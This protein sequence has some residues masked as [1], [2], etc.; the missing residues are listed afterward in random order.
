[1]HKHIIE[2][3]KKLICLFAVSFGVVAGMNAQKNTVLLY[4]DAGFNTTKASNDDLNKGFNMNLGVG[5]QFDHNWT[6]GLTGGYSTLRERP[7]GQ[8][9]WDLYD[10]YSFAPFIRYSRPMG[11]LFTFF[12]QGEFGYIGSSMGQTNLNTRSNYNGTY[13]SVFPAIGLNLG[14]GWALNFNVGGLGYSSIKHENSNS[15]SR[16]FSLTFGQ[17]YN[18]G[19]SWN[20]LCKTNKNFKKHNNREKDSDD[21]GYDNWKRDRRNK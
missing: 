9:Y 17:H 7:N 13:L 8:T 12:T 21:D 2:Y 20:I 4:G 11:S 19:L 1:M 14:K 16:G 6:V 10:S 15:P 18:A 3:M 5:Y